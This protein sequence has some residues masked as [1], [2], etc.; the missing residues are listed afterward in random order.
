[1]KE[2]GFVLNDDDDGMAQEE[3]AFNER[4]Q[5]HPWVKKGT[6]N[7]YSISVILLLGLNTVVIVYGPNSIGVGRGILHSNEVSDALSL[8]KR[9]EDSMIWPTLIS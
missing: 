7:L 1:M 3:E 4:I 5:I 8:I 2:V 6:R 9:K